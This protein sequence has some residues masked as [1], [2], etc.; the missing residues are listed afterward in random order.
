MDALL[1][2]VP[3]V[4]TAGCV[5]GA[6]QVIRRALRTSRMWAHGLT[7]EARCLNTYTRTSGGN[8]T[9]VH[10]TLHHVY[11]FTTREGERFRFDEAGGDSTVVAGDHLVVRYLAER[12]QWATALQPAR[13]RLILGTAVLLAILAVVGVGA[14]LFAV[15]ARSAV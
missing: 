8:D 9:A 6:V 7:A 10:S 3:G 13:G 2:L 14:V 15:S 5:F 12:P 11:E 1:Y 4:I